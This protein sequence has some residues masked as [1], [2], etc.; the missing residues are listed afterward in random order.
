MYYVF[1]FYVNFNA[2]KIVAFT[3]FAVNINKKHYEEYMTSISLSS[4]GK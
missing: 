3:A 2:F 1:N 4:L